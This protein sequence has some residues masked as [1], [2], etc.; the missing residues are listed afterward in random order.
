MSKQDNVIIGGHGDSSEN[1]ISVNYPDNLKD[2]RKSCEF[3][4]KYSDDL[5]FSY[6]NGGYNE[7]IKNALIKEGCKMAYTIEPKTITDLDTIDYLEFPRYDGA[8][9]KF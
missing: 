2:I 3:V 8:Q 5:I 1:L 9:I 7:I 6:P 4:K